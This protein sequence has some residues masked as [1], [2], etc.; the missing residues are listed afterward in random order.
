V[1][2]R[3][4][5]RRV[6]PGYS[7]RSV[8]ES[9]I[10]RRRADDR[11]LMAPTSR[12]A[13]EASD[14]AIARGAAGAEQGEARGPDRVGTAV[15]AGA[16]ARGSSL[17]WRGDRCGAAGARS[18]KGRTGSPPGSTTGSPPTDAAQGG[19]PRGSWSRPASCCWPPTGCRGGA[20]RRRGGDHALVVRLLADRLRR[21]GRPV[22]YATG[23]RVWREFG[24]PA[25]PVRDVQVHHRPG[26]SCDG[27][28][29]RRARRRLETQP[30]RRPETDRP[31]RS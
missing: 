18:H 27:R 7:R 9:W 22:S 6:R 30:L 10:G 24:D 31:P 21:A 3:D 4:R 28:R 16:T 15:R 11:G 19:E 1:A 25:A 14:G 17:W 29:R 5:R 12:A 2:R 8:A 13:L 20:G 26:A 23:A